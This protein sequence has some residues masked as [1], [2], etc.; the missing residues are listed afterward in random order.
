MLR[1]T[2]LSLSLPLSRLSWSGAGGTGPRLWISCSSTPTP[3]RKSCSR[4]PATCAVPA[5]RSFT[6]HAGETPSPLHSQSRNLGVV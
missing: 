5:P 1:S 2:S 4:W 3:W 6:C